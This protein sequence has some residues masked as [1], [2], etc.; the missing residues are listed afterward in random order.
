MITTDYNPS[1]LEVRF[2]EVLSEMKGEIN[3]RLGIYEITKI[4]NKY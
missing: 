4:E 2:V 1:P 3:K